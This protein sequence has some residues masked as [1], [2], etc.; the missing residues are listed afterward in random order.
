MP[1]FET[2]P[3]HLSSSQARAVRDVLR[4]CIPCN[5]MC[6]RINSI[7]HVRYNHAHRIDGRVINIVLR[8]TL[9]TDRYHVFITERDSLGTDGVSVPFGHFPIHDRNLCRVRHT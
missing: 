7:G 5:I 2:F 8:R 3:S 1:V 9:E 6:M 4:G